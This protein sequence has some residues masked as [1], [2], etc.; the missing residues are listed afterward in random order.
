MRNPAIITL[1]A[2]LA[3]AG[4]GT[5]I[6]F[7]QQQIDLG[8]LCSFRSEVYS[9]GA[10]ICIGKNRVLRCD[11]PGPNAGATT[12]WTIFDDQSKL[13]TDDRDVKLG[14]ACNIGEPTK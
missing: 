1:N 13:S 2:V 10:I 8:H 12:H 14:D 9:F 7:A 3:F 5:S 11:G 4:V 6:A